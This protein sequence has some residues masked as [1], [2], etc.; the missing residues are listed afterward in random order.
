MNPQSCKVHLKLAIESTLSTTRN[1]SV[2]LRPS[3][4]ACL[5]GEQ[6]QRAYSGDVIKYGSW[7]CQKG[8]RGLCSRE[9]LNIHSFLPDDLVLFLAGLL[10]LAFTSTP[11]QDVQKS[12]LSVASTSFLAIE[13]SLTTIIMFIVCC[14]LTSMVADSSFSY[15]LELLTWDFS[16]FRT[17]IHM[18]G[19]GRKPSSFLR[20]SWN[21]P[22][23]Q[24]LVFSRRAYLMSATFP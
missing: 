24:C 23:W 19:E 20:W 10:F 9:Q 4:S 21:I 6:R 2:S 7:S 17:S 22:L 11:W 5:A 3:I 18:P 8:P 15:Q 13:M 12:S 1:P 14:A 16:K